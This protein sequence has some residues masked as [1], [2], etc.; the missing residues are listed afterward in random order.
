MRGSNPL[1]TSGS[2]R[3]L[4]VAVLALVVL[5]ALAYRSRSL[6]TLQG[7]SWDRLW[8]SVQQ[9][10]VS[11]L[12]LSLATIYTCYA[13][14]AL[15]WVRFSRYLGKPTFVNVFTST[16]IGFATIF[17]LGRAGEP[18]RPL[19]IA[20]KD[21]L[22]VSGTFGIYVLE[23]VF[24]SGSTAVILGLS[25]L[26]FPGTLSSGGTNVV[27]EARARAAGL[28][29][30]AGLLAAVIFLVYFRLHGAVALERRLA[31]WRASTR[32][33]RRAAGI[34]AGFSEGLQAIQ[35]V[36]DLVAATF[37]STVHWALIAMVYLWVAHSFGGG[38]AAIDFPGAM[39]V[40]A[41]TMVGSAFQLPA[42]GGGSQAASFLAFTVI[43]GVEKEPAAAAAIMLW[44]ITFSAVTLVGAP[45]LIREG[46]SMGELRRLA[47]AEA[48]AEAAGTHLA[49]PDVSTKPGEL[50]R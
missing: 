31:G 42:V 48:E 6:I 4:L 23:R 3:K 19:L 49:E 50:L 33:R 15:R 18:I 26:L 34:F 5:G 30:L 14:R 13:I 16:L 9:A 32:W 11:L 47:R 8:H 17:L 1:A 25:L 41:F 22:P 10:R 40:L 12:L 36:P 21:R 39:L 35:T 28:V 38:L 2:L 27:W 24:D 45:L 37:Y 20:R 29:L 7:F 43:F 46:W 44:L